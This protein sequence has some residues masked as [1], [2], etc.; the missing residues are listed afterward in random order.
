M[1][2]VDIVGDRKICFFPD[3]VTKSIKNFNSFCREFMTELDVILQAYKAA[4]RCPSLP[5]LMGKISEDYISRTRTYTIEISPLGH[6]P[7]LRSGHSIKMMTKNVCEALS[8]LHDAGLVHRDVR[9]PNVV[10][11]SQEQ[12]MLIDLETVAASPFRLPEGFQY[13]RGWSIEMLE[14]SFYT[15]MLDM[16]QLGILLEL[17]VHWMTEISKSAL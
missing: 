1:F 5:Q 9:L 16:Y 15:P 17:D 10:Q 4:E 13:F 8:A 7:I 6:P 12:F 2:T 14:D 11:V 3:R